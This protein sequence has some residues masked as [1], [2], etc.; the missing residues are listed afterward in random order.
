MNLAWK[1][2]L[3]M[4]FGSILRRLRKKAGL[5]IKRLA[6]DLDVTYAYISRLEN[7]DAA[8]SEEFVTRVAEYFGYDNDQLLLAAGKVPVDIR[9]I[10][11]EHPHESLNLLRKRFGQR[12]KQRSTQRIV[13]RRR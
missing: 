4:N 12:D 3:V 8:P 1:S 11:R 7:N 10:L 2:Y 9:H 6:P 13:I 5:S